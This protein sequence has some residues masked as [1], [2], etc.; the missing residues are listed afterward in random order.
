MSPTTQQHDTERF[1]E[2]PEQKECSTRGCKN[3]VESRDRLKR[4][5][6]ECVQDKIEREAKLDADMNR[7]EARE[8]GEVVLDA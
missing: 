4:K 2:N 7:Q 8:A 6:S 1:A 5:C 3:T